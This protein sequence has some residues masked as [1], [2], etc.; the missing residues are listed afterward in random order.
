MLFA[1]KQ[2]VNSFIDKRPYR[3]TNHRVQN[4]PHHRRPRYTKKFSVNLFTCHASGNITQYIFNII[5]AAIFTAAHTINYAKVNTEDSSQKSASGI[6][7]NTNA[8]TSR[9]LPGKTA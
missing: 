3:L 8:K 5:A 1:V 2:F 4:F 7:K 9:F 6:V